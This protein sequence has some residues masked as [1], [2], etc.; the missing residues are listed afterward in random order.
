[1][2][3]DRAT[4]LR[5]LPSVDQLLRRLA[6]HAEI[7]GL[8]RARL[9]LLTQALSSNQTLHVIPSGRF[10]ARPDFH[11]S[12][13]VTFEPLNEDQDPLDFRLEIPTP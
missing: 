6:G 1:M 10:R 5:S 7:R 8:T 12:Q 4:A 2:S 13:G 3:A 11:D 9:L